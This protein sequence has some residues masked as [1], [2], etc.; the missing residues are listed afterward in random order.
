MVSLSTAMSAIF[1]IQFSSSGA[2][3]MAQQVKVLATHAWKQV[4]VS[5]IHEE[6]GEHRPHRA[7]L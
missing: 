6:V 1:F 2:H 3:E 7:A 5:G 4:L